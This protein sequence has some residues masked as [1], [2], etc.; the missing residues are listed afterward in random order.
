MTS[1]NVPKVSSEITFPAFFVT[2][3]TSSR[4]SVADEILDAVNALA[5]VQKDL[6]MSA[7]IV[8]KIS[9]CTAAEEM[10]GCAGY[11]EGYITRLS[12]LAEKWK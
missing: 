5:Q 7:R 2:R 8:R 11:L 10:D 1:H 9:N 3:S 4:N 6:K 12:D